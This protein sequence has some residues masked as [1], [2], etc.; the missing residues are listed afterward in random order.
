VSETAKAP[1]LSGAQQETQH[2][3]NV[4]AEIWG[5]LCLC[6]FFDVTTATGYVLKSV[7]Y[8]L[9]YHLFLLV[10]RDAEGECRWSP[11]HQFQKMT[12]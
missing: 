10:L 9:F 6:S 7:F 12:H 8:Y 5:G 11:Y 4:E 1:P 3:Q 2:S